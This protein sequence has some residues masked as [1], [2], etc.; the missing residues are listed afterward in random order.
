MVAPESR[1]PIGWRVAFAGL[2]L[3]LGGGL[4]CAFNY[5]PYPYGP[6]Q[7]QYGQMPPPGQYGQMPPPGQYGQM[8]GQPMPWQYRPMQPDNARGA[9]PSA[10]PQSA[11]GQ[12][13]GQMSGQTQGYPSPYQ[14]GYRQGWP[15]GY[16]PG[17]A[18]PSAPR[19]SDP[20]RLEWSLEETSPYI[21]QSLVLKLSLIGPDQLATAEPQ[22]PP[23]NDVLIQRLS[24]PTTSY[25]TGSDGRRE[26][27]TG[28]L[29]TL[30]PLRTGTLEIPPLRIDGTRQGGFG[31]SES[32][33]SVADTPIRLQVRP[34]M[35]SVR[36]WLP[37][38]SLSLKATIDRPDLV[39]P[40]QPVT[41]VLELE[42]VGGGAGQLPSLEDQLASPDFRVYREQTLV[43][44]RLSQDGRDLDGKR[45]EYYTLIPQAGGNLRLPEIAV[46]WWNVNEE[47]KR[48]A[49]LPIRTVE[50]AG[51]GGR[52]GWPPSLAGIASGWAWVP[53]V[54][55]LLVLAGYWGGVL[56][57]RRGPAGGPGLAVLVRRG[58]GQAAGLA[59]ASAVAAARRL[60]PTPFAARLR[61]AGLELVPESTR[62]LRCVRYANR[63]ATP[64]DWCERFEQ[65][66]RRWL[67]APVRGLVPSM[68]E[69]ILALRPRAD[70]V[71]VTR[72]MEQ[73]DSALYGRQDIDFPRWKRDFMR[74]VG[75]LPSLLRH[76][77]GEARIRRARLPALNPSPA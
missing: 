15:A 47:G 37:L 73:L 72:L 17:Y 36:P 63:A 3:S 46:P 67:R 61:T 6:P 59:R 56:Y 2:A 35:P 68:A 41:L 70:R 19:A 74:Q 22:I 30:T 10:Q 75:R 1:G 33:R 50:I 57:R 5:P 48:Y 9:P 66:A 27:T 44:T 65:S 20:P 49:R 64:A 39:E 16:S 40:G 60:R 51:A 12:A 45:T 43:D 13:P 54:A 18:Q 62:L 11:A 34:A 26:L 76:R 32:Y 52:F 55:V 4:A 38:K 31:G 28:F 69:R 25:R 7:G 42:A 58:L 24:G 53:L 21:Q 71:R 14:P 77:C 8:P 29:L 23:S